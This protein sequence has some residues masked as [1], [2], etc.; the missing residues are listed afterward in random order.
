MTA[1]L[2]SE[3]V[4]LDPHVTTA[5]ISRTFGYHVFD[6]LFSMDSKG[7]IH[8]QMV[9]SVRTSGDKL[10]WDFTLRTGLTF[11]DG[12][13]VTAADCVAS[14]RRWAPLDSLGR[15]LVAATDTMTA[16]D[17]NSFRIALKRP[18]PLMLDVLGKPNAA[19]PFIMPERIIPPGR[20]DRIKEIVGSGP[21]VF[22]TARWRTGDTMVLTRNN[23]YIPR[24][25]PADFV[26]GGKKV[27][28][29]ELVLKAIPDASTGATALIA[30]EID[31]MQYLPFDWMG[32]LEAD[33]GLSIMSLSGVDMFQGNFRLNHASGPFADPEVRRVLWQLVDQDEIMQ[34][35]GIPDRYRV[36][37]CPS[38][39]MCDAPLESNAGASIARFSI[40]DARQALSRSR[41]R[42]EPVIMLQ[43]SG[44]ISQTAGD[45]LADH[46][47]SAGF[48][49]QPELMDWG[50]V[51]AR[52]AKRDGWSLFPVYSNGIDMDSPLTHF[53]VAN[54]CADYPGWSCDADMTKLLEDF[55]NAPDAAA[56]RKIADEIQVAAYKLTPSVMWGQFARPAGYRKKLKNMIVSAFPMFWQVTV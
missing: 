47:K 13:P 15:M 48:N 38:F 55:A 26:S 41:Y 33:A 14:L 39:W 27:L 28:I 7:S 51:L 53:Y 18:F 32:K 40:E 23:R 31:Y 1:L 35:I 19:V 34:A 2:E 49:V 16:T 43:V 42:G 56:R 45:V 10:T 11:H 36:K 6:T 52:R 12:A 44:S 3:V 29:D 17:A 5:A 24:T 54:N 22:D 46:M 25:E 21:F 37:T 8:P 9:D 30:G 20:G 4:I 50:T